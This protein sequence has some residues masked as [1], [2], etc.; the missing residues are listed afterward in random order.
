M[1][2]HWGSWAH[3]P[4]VVGV[5]PPLASQFHVTAAANASD[6]AGG[7]RAD[8]PL[9][10]DLDAAPGAD[11]A[12][13]ADGPHGAARAHVTNAVHGPHAAPCVPPRGGLRDAVPS[14]GVCAISVLSE[15]PSVAQGS[16][17]MAGHH[18]RRGG[19]T[20]HLLDTPPLPDQSDHRGKQRNLPLG[21]SDRALSA[22]Q[23]FGSQN[24][25]PPALIPPAPVAPS[26]GTPTRA[27]PV[28]R[29]KHESPWH[30]STISLFPVHWAHSATA[31]SPPLTFVAPITPAMHQKGRDLRGGPRGG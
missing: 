7:L 13:A 24:P 30:C 23:I 14:P 9:P 22:A 12:D 3:A 8:P 15:V 20:P 17:R 18:R 4:N 19:G 6:A 5:V 25:P 10:R 31:P 28:L 1:G 27:T 2:D 16:V 29:H 21:K 11:A 26:H